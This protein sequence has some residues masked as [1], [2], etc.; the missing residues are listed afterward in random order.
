M[1][2]LIAPALRA[3]EQCDEPFFLRVVLRSAVWA[4]LTFVLLGTAIGWVAWHALVHS[5]WF[6]W[7]GPFLGVAVAALSAL[8]LFQPLAAALASLAVEGVSAAVEARFYPS[9]PPATAA[10]LAQQIWDGVM[11]GA[12]VLVMQLLALV[13]AIV[14][15]G[16]GLLLGWAVAAWAIGRGLFVAVAMRRMERR[17]AR[18]LYRRRRWAV[19]TQGAI[20]AACGFVPVVNIFAAVIGIAAM[21]HV[22]HQGEPARL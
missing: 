11:L 15:P 8:Y 12:G 20:I 7:L 9:L 10:P 18:K 14:V 3:V 6:G 16:L 1:G 21:V 22:M 4:A 17:D 19:L 5:E 13:L 2:G